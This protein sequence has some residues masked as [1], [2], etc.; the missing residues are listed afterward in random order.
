MPAAVIEL[1]SEERSWAMVHPRQNVLDFQKTDVAK[2]GV[3]IAS[4]AIAGG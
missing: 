2:V 1:V 3:V 4:V